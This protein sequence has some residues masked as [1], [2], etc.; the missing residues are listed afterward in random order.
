MPP[1]D[2]I[3]IVADNRKARHD[4]AI[5]DSVECGIALTGSEIKS[6]R[7]G[8][9]QLKDSHGEIRKGEVWLVGVHISEYRNAGYAQHPVERDRKL[10]LRREEID[11]LERKVREKGFTLV[12]LKVYLKRGRAKVELALARGRKAHDKRA[13]LKEKVADREIDRVMKKAR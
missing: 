5:D 12:P 11:R 3:K 10:L 8:R 13:V 9:I 6:I 4:Y 1:T 7:D 2:G